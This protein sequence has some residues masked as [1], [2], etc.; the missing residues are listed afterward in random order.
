[1]LPVAAE[2]CKKPEDNS[3]NTQDSNIDRALYNELLKDLVQ[4]IRDGIR[5]GQR[6]EDGNVTSGI[7]AALGRIGVPPT[8]TSGHDQHQ[9][10]RAAPPPPPPVPTTGQGIE[11]Q[12][13]VC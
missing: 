5:E 13:Q 8:N 2:K 3:E 4:A 9:R 11:V 10:R 6:H 12:S 7:L 1:M